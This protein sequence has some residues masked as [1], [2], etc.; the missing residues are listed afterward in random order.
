MIKLLNLFIILFISSNSSKIEYDSLRKSNNEIFYSE[1][2]LKW[3]DFKEAKTTKFV[4]AVAATGIGYEVYV[5]G[6]NVSVKAFC[7][8]DKDQS[9][10]YNGERNKTDYI[11]NH[12]QKHFDITYLF[13]LRFIKILKKQNKLTE[14]LVDKIYSEILIE[15]DN[16]QLK[17]DL[18]TNHSANKVNQ[19]IWDDHIFQ[20]IKLYK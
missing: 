16:F 3:S 18:E 6:E 14:Q 17:Y 15:K 13:C 8:F 19:K 12:E 1:Y 11:L 7:Y 5:D 10:V 9:Y 4:A 2:K 20:Q